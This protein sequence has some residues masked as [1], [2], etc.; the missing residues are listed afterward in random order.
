M[1]GQLDQRGDIFFLKIRTVP[2]RAETNDF[3]LMKSIAANDER[4]GGVPYTYSSPAK[5]PRA[6]RCCEKSSGRQQLPL[7]DESL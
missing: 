2:K 3:E 6:A 1:G 4:I 5:V 7:L